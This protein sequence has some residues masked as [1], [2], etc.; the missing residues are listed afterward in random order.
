MGKALALGGNLAGNAEPAFDF[1]VSGGDT[2][3]VFFG[4][5][6]SGEAFDSDASA[7]LSGAGGEDFGYAILGAGDLN[8]DGLD[9]LVVGAPGADA[10]YIFMGPVVS[11][12]APDES[13]QA[14]VA[15]KRFGAALAGTGDINLDGFSDMLI[16][17]PLAG[18]ANFTF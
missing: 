10:V 12:K 17:A 7:Q 5:P 3:Y 4:S 6:G 1:A 8:H 14:P 13:I 2:V 15:G 9:D 18:E 11:G 16:G